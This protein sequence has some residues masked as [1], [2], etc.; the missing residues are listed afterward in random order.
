MINIGDNNTIV[1][2]K[3]NGGIDMEV[4]YTMDFNN[5]ETL[6]HMKTEILNQGLGNTLIFAKTSETAKIPTKDE[7]NMGYDIYAD[8]HEEYMLINPHET[9]MIPTGICSACSEDYA[10]VLKER[11]STGTKGIAQRCGV[12]DSGYRGEWFV[13]ITNTTNNPIAIIK[14]ENEELIDDL[15]LDHI[16]YPYEKAICQAVVLPVP[17]MNVKEIS[18]EELKSI[19]SKRGEGNRGSSGK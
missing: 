3:I 11:G 17:K 1:N 15:S 4:G 9:K 13:P 7:E 6:E 16:I 10:I 18:L 5:K 12:I 2:T 8:F 14:K 19:P